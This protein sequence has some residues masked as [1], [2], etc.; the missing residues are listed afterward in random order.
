[1][2]LAD[3]ILITH[4]DCMDGCGC[5][6]LF[7]IMGGQDKN[8]HFVSHAVVNETISQLVNGYSGHLVIADISPNEETCEVLDRRGDVTLIDHHITAEPL[9]KYSWA[10][11][12]NNACGTLLVWNHF[13]KSYPDLAEYE[14][15]A[16]M[17]DDYDRWIKKNPLSQSFA[18]LQSVAGSKYF[19]S[20][21]IKDSRVKLTPA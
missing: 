18:D 4:G 7:K 2:S 13:L 12:D 6:I 5:A 9:T 11:I 17:I 19:I 8:I 15:M 3:T 14:G 20:R 21:F 10:H 16:R 1:M